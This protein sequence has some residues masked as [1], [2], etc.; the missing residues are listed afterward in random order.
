MSGFGGDP[1]STGGEDG[2]GD[3]EWTLSEKGGYGGGSMCRRRG[4]RGRLM[5]YRGAGRNQTW[6]LCS[7]SGGED[8]PAV[9]KDKPGWSGSDTA[10]SAARERWEGRAGGGWSAFWSP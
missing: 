7:E 9:R 1:A 10:G 8:P 6:G 3:R 2:G 5:Q 4:S